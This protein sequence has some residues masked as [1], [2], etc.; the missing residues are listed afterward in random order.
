MKTN[1]AKKRPRPLAIPAD[2]VVLNPRLVKE[3]L[4][5]YRS[6]AALVPPICRRARQEFGDQAELILDLY[7]DHESDDS[8][9]ILRVRLPQ[10]SS[11][12]MSRIDQVWKEFADDFPKTS[13][14][15]TITTDFPKPR[16]Q[17]P[18]WERTPRNSLSRV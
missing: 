17:T 8:F 6:L 12:F 14:W 3:Y 15:L 13:G 10:Y 18:V 4:R 2:V 11:D 16:S 1:A 9:L 5:R 7:R